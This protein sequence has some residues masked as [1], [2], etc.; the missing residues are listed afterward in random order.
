MEWGS[1][2]EV[3]CFAQSF[4]W[5]KFSKVCTSFLA[6][7]VTEV[8]VTCEIFKELFSFKGMSICHLVKETAEIIF[9]KT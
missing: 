7:A 2:S 4:S 9:K 6:F 3:F 8:V 5:C 1:K